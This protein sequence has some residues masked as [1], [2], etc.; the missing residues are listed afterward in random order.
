MCFRGIVISFSDI[1]VTYIL[2]KIVNNLV[3]VLKKIYTLET[4]TKYRPVKPRSR[5]FKLY[6]TEES[7][8]DV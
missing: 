7:M 6:F 1:S 4:I 8:C 3:Q 2:N 5:P